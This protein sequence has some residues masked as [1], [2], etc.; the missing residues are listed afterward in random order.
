MI[1]P[2][3]LQVRFTL[4]DSWSLAGN[5]LPLRSPATL[6]LRRNV[7]N[8]ETAPRRTVAGRR[9]VTSVTEPL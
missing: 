1:S 2:A 3:E 7:A 5:S 6:N 8:V 9:A 4:Q